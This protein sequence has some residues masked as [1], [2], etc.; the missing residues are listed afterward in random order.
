MQTEAMSEDNVRWLHPQ[1]PHDL[2]IQVS[3]HQPV[4]G[5][6]LD[7]DPWVMWREVRATAIRQ[8][9]GQTQFIDSHGTVVATWDSS[10]V[11]QIE[12]PDGFALVP[13]ELH[14]WWAGPREHGPSKISKL[15]EKRPNAYRRWEEDEDERL[16]AEFREGKGLAEIAELHGRGES[17]ILS[18]LVKLH[19]AGGDDR[20]PEEER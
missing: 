10:I 15:R 6:G 9:N 12:W 14:R 4:E 18:R 19:L 16:A 11:G 2:P 17:A 3:F 1:Q 20:S 8:D 5:D 13:R 7:E